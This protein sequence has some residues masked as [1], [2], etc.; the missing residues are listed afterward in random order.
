MFIDFGLVLGPH[1][2]SCLPSHGLNSMFLLG[3]FPSHILHRFGGGVLGGWSS[4]TAFCVWEVLQN[5]G[6]RKNR[7][8]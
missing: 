8:W 2:E 7:F 6:F 5:T 1:F 3:L 4:E